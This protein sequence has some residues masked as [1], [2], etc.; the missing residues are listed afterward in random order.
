L[1]RVENFSKN[2]SRNADGGIGC[3]LSLNKIELRVQTSQAKVIA[4]DL[5]RSV[6]Q[7]QASQLFAL[8]TRKF[9]LL[10]QSNQSLLCPT[11]WQLQHEYC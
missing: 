8:A 4:L 2:I 5:F 10:S 9:I 3:D 6:I 7:A 11:A 1:K